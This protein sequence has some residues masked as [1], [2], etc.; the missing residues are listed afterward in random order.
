MA[1]WPVKV[2]GIETDEAKSD[3][4]F[5]RR[6]ANGL[7]GVDKL[8]AD[9]AITNAGPARGGYGRPGRMEAS[10]WGGDGEAKGEKIQRPFLRPRRS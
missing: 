4:L 1:Y 10:F 9:L 2:P 3:V 5:H 7:V 8:L 6:M